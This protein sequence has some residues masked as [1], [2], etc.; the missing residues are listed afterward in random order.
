MH[1][2][3]ISHSFTLPWLEVPRCRDLG[4]CTQTPWSTLL[5]PCPGVLEGNAWPGRGCLMLRH[6]WKCHWDQAATEHKNGNMSCIL[7]MSISLSDCG[8]CAVLHGCHIEWSCGADI[9][10]ISNRCSLYVGARYILVINTLPTTIII[11]GFNAISYINLHILP[12][13]MQEFF[14]QN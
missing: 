8:L 12:I 6:I 5:P 7:A 3:M 14:K 2:D 1:H 11:I 10:I 4:L 13:K 9:T